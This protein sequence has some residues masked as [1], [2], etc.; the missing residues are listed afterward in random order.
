MFGHF[1][2]SDNLDISNIFDFR[3]FLMFG[4]FHRSDIFAFG[5]FRC[6]NVIEFHPFSMF[7]HFLFSNIFYFRTFSTFEHIRYSDIVLCLTKKHCVCFTCLVSSI[8]SI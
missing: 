8:F 2:R 7:G 1:R 6:S 3:T 4:R 5:Q